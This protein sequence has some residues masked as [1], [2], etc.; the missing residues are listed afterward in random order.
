MLRS[1]RLVG[2]KV[3]DSPSRGKMGAWRILN[4]GH[5][6]ARYIEESKRH[7][8]H[9]PLLS[10][11]ETAEIL[12]VK[13]GT[14]RQMKKRRQLQGKADGNKTLYSVQQIRRL[15][16]ERE[17]R[18]GRQG[19]RSYSPILVTWARGLVTQDTP[20]QAQALDELLRQAVGVPEPAKSCYVVG[21]WRHFDA[22]NSLLLSARLEGSS[23]YPVR[24][25]E[26]DNADC[27]AEGAR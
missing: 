10:G 15:L 12:G 21:L 20:V 5:K 24:K 3:P 18:A 25:Q 1:G 6:F 19:R 9:V 2:Y 22:V 8:E 16:W 4:P 26:G 11:G 17:R 14:V 23:T 13:P 27:I 7:L